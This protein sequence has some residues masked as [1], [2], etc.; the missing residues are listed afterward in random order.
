V[1]AEEAER[2]GLAERVVASETLIDAS[3]SLASEIAS[4]APAAV[5]STRATLRDGLAES[6]RAAMAHELDEQAALAGTP[7]AR[8][9]VLAM[10]EGRAPRFTG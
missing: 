8:E 6:A 1:K 9:G 7:D 4:G 5:A 10:L 3:L 2:I